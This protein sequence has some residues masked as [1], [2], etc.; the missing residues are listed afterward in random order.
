VVFDLVGG[1]IQ[2]RSW[3]VLKKGGVLVSTLNE[4]SQDQ[5]AA[6]GARGLRYTVTESGA[7]LAEIG[8]LIDAGRVKPVITRTYQL[9]DAAAAERFLEQEHPAGK[10]VL[11]VP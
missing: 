8:V 4:P 9:K 7:D 6:R 5:A 3:Q 10:V 11:S 1:D 2:Q